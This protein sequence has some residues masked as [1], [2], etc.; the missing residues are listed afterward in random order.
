MQLRHC[1]LTMLLPVDQHL[2]LLCCLV[3]CNVNPRW[4]GATA[5][6]AGSAVS[7]AIAAAE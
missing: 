5:A 4:E 3:C 6:V 7:V 1:Y 2:V